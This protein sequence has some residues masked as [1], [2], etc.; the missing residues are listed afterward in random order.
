MTTIANVVFGAIL[1]GLTLGPAAWAGTDLSP[2]QRS[3]THA[4]SSTVLPGPTEAPDGP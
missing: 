2:D 4:M 1:A 3:A